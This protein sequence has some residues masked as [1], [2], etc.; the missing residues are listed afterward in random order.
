MSALRAFASISYA[1]RTAGRAGGT[2]RERLKA[3]GA[4]SSLAKADGTI[5]YRDA[6]QRRDAFLTS[7]ASAKG[8]LVVAGN[9]PAASRGPASPFQA[10]IEGSALSM[11][12]DGSMPQYLST[13]RMAFT[14]DARAD[15][16]KLVDRVIEAGLFG[17][18]PVSL[19]ARV[20]REPDRG[21]LRA[22]WVGAS[23]VEGRL[24]V[25]KAGDRTH[26]DGMVHF[27]RLNFGD[28]ASDA[29]HAAAAALERSEGLRIMSNLRLNIGKIDDTD[30]RIAFRID[31]EVSTSRA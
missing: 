31:E 23:P 13:R 20:E 21:H 1:P 12:L 28:L 30:R 4:N 3:A 11:T 27:R 16:L 14:L 25:I 17:T 9:G 29:G 19:H 7:G 22:V 18:Q 6:K 5:R 10:A 2:A 26:L 24:E 8:G 15:D